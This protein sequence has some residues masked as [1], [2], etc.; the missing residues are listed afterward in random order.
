MVTIMIRKT[1]F[2]SAVLVKER[3]VGNSQCRKERGKTSVSWF[4][5][6]GLV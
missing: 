1:G 6:E 2:S 3:G 4:G 5:F